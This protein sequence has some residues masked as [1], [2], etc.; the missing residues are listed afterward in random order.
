M[1]Y[2]THCETLILAAIDSSRVYHA[3]LAELE[4][5]HIRHDVKEPFRLRQEVAG[6]LK[7][8]DSALKA[9]NDHEYTHKR[10]AIG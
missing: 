8:R 4:S 10:Q 6:A 9:L 2:C 5:A 1:A 3:M 7:N